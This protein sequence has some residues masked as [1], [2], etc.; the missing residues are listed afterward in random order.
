MRSCVLGHMV[1][2]VLETERFLS[3]VDSLDPP[4]IL[5]KFVLCVVRVASLKRQQMYVAFTQCVPGPS[6]LFLHSSVSV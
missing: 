5:G 1:S 2:H 6:G 4:Y 3:M